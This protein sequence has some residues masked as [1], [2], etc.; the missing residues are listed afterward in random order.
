MNRALVTIA[1]IAFGSTLFVRAVDPIVLK[2]ADGFAVAPS[3]AALLITAFALPYAMMQP[4]LG[5]MADVFGKPRLMV[6]CLTIGV[7]ASLA[8]AFAPTFPLLM[9]TRVVSGAA[10]GGVFP[11][12]VA[13]VGDLFPISQRQVAIGRVVATGMMGNLIGA[14]L[15]GI[16][17][18]FWG[19]RGAFIVT[20]VLAFSMLVPSF[21][22]GRDSAPAERPKLMTALTNYRVIFTN[23]LAKVCFGAVFFDA[24]VIFGLFPYMATILHAQGE[25]RATIVGLIIAGFGFGAVIYSFIVR[26]LLDLF[27]DRWLMAIG[28][29]IMA[30]G[31]LLVPLQLS[32]PVLAAVFLVMGVAFFMLHGSIQIYVTELAPAARASAMAM[33]S[34][35]FFFGQAVGPI[36]YGLGFAHLGSGLTFAVSAVVIAIVG[37]WAAAGLKHTHPQ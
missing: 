37:V 13:I 3:S 35:S 26:R 1:L 22:F 6:A 33:H 23:P 28:G 11:V 15:A 24:M 21:G 14:T 10:C 2:I 12:A 32:W 25:T 36:A 16:V 30:G 27:G 4:I 20:G 31:L 29:F 19:W 17:G 18:D 8:S 5:A 7:C 9:A 34:S